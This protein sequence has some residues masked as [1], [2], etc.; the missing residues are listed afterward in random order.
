ME[1]STTN[2]HPS[3]PP[4]PRRKDRER[5]ASGPPA[6]PRQKA[7]KAGRPPEASAQA[8]RKPGTKEREVEQKTEVK[9]KSTI[10]DIDSVR[11]DVKE[12]NLGLLEAAEQEDSKCKV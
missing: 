2:G 9:V 11:E 8:K 4:Q 3:H 7:S 1:K 5:G 6:S 10:V 12:D